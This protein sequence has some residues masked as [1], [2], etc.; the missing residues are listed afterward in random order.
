MFFNV[1]GAKRPKMAR[2]VVER[3]QI[4]KISWYNYCELIYKGIHTYENCNC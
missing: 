1:V 3:I 4:F 2:I